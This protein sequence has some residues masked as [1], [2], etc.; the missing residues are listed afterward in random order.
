[1]RISALFSRRFFFRVLVY[2]RRGYGLYG[3]FISALNMANILLIVLTQVLHVPLRN[4]L[5]LIAALFIAV[6][7]GM[8]IIGWW[9]FRKG[10]REQEVA[11]HV[12]TD[13]VAMA[14]LSVIFKMAQAAAVA[15]GSA[16]ARLGDAELAEIAEDLRRSVEE[17]R[18]RLRALGIAV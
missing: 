2:F 3:V 11:I 4:T 16:A 6:V 18:A 1:M 9:D 14:H 17:G 7:I 13:P 8:A 12:K 15:L 10:Q 5:L